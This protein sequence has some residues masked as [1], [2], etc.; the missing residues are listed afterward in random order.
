MNIKTWRNDAAARI[1]DTCGEEYACDADWLLCDAL[2]CGRGGLRLRMQEELSPDLLDALNQALERRLTG[3][4]LQ[5]IEG[6][7]WFM[8]HRFLVTKDV[9]IPRPD[10]EILAEEAIRLAGDRNPAVLDLCTGSG[11]IAC[12]VALAC[13]GAQVIAS[14][15]SPNALRVAKENARELGAKVEFLQGDLFEP[16]R[17]AKFGLIACNPPYLSAEDMR[18]LSGEVRHEPRLALEGGED[19][20]AFYRRIAEEVRDY[21]VPGGALLL[22]VG[23][24]QAQAVLALL[25]GGRTIRDFN[26]IERVVVFG[27]SGI[28]RR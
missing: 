12:S 8:G 4:P 22:E 6:F 20:L 21:L 9:L 5:Y 27:A 15:I 19:G 28:P 10:T 13:T 11:A 24:G 26:G 14:D 16:V 25:G 7:A 1:T 17:G 2:R 3:E 23:A 18:C